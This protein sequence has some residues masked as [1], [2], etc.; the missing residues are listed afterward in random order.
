MLRPAAA[1]QHLTNTL[2]NALQALAEAWHVFPV[3]R[4]AGLIKFTAMHHGIGN[5]RSFA[6]VFSYVP[7][8]RI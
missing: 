1:D 4:P 2:H 6:F 3:E 8:A 5:D 7:V